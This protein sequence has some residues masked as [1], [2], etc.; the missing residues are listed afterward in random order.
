MPT[1]QYISKAGA[2][3]TIDAADEAGALKSI[4]GLADPSSGVRLMPATSP[5]PVAPGT[6]TA[7]VAPDYSKAAQAAGAAGLGVKDYSAL[8]GPSPEEQ[9]AA[10]DEIAKQF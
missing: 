7:P 2:P 4:T 9:K 6:P 5:A 8:L 1:F 10:Q 3:A